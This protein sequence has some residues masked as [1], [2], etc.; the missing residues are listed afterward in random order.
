MHPMVGERA[1]GALRGAVLLGASFMAVSAALAQAGPGSSSTTATPSAPGDVPP[2]TGDGAAAV[3]GGGASAEIVVTGSRLRTGFTAPT[4][5]SVVGAARLEERAAPSIA[6]AL[7]EVPSFRPSNGPATGELA[8]TAGYVGGRV[9]DLRGLGAPRTLTLV[10]GK[11]FVPATTQATVDTN[12]IPSILLDRAE[13]VTGGASA[14]YGS[15]AVAGV[16][17]LILDKKLVGLK[18]SVQDVVTKYGDGNDP[19]VGIAYGAKISERLHLVIGGEYENQQGVGDC[20][21]RAFCR[22]E[23]L[24]FGRNP[25]Y[26]AIPALNILGDVRPWSASFNGVTTPPGSAYAGKL[27]PTLRPIDGITFADDG[28]PRRFQFGSPVNTLYQVGGE[29]KGQNIYFKDLFFVSPTERYAVTG[30]L[31]WDVTPDIKASVMVNYGHLRAE[32]SSPYYR[33]TALT[34]R[35]DNPFLPRSSDPTLDIPTLLRQANLTSFTLGKGFNEIG[36]TAYVTHD[37]VYRVVASLE[38]KLGG[39][40]SWDAYYQYGENHFRDDVTNAVVSSRIAKALDPVRN[41]AGQI[42]CR[43]NADAITTNDDP[44]C[45]AY[46][47]F[48]NQ[49]S[50]AAKAY[51][52]GNAFQT[53]VDT[54]HVAAANLRGSLFNLPYG[55]V[56]IAVG[57]EYRND[58]IAGDADALS[59]SLAF[60]AGNGSRISGQIAVAEGYVEGEVPLLSRLSFA[61]ELSLNGAV[62]RT[63]YRRSSDFFPSS[64]VNVT[65]YKF[66]GVYEPIPAIRFRATKS[67]DIRAP[68]V[69]ELFGPTTSLFGILNDPAKG[70]QQVNIPIFG[71]SNPN[72]APE[73]AD[74]ITAGIVIKPQGGFLGRFRASADYYNIKVKNA[75]AT[76]GQQNIATRCFQGDTLSCAQITRDADGNIIQIRDVFQNVNEQINRGIDGEINY[77]QPLGSLGNANLRLLATYVIDFITVDAVGPTDRAGQT[78]L[79]GGTPVGLPDLQLDA[80]VSW[81]VGRFTL[82]THVKYINKGFYNAAFIGPDDP[83]YNILSVSSAN[84]NSVPSRTYLDMLASYRIGA[85]TGRQMT[86]YFGVDNITNAMPPLNAGSHG[87]G[88]TVL[89]SPLGTTFKAGARVSF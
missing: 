13:V 20:Q 50:A 24:N 19:V 6:D 83:N 37:D 39:S 43:V 33:S 38:G 56:S 42:V 34:I 7:N 63:H 16:V 9:L 64:T 77:R 41:A 17:N 10:D 8:P 87:T 71:G 36:R 75:I 5:V 57:G 40:W 89:F 46:N 4:P 68:N 44:A 45:V 29:G 62:R 14:Q 82:N 22:T 88:N 35:A 59:K 51:V 48:G 58:H 28:T 47:P 86:V 54:Q 74:T 53:N 26:T 23:V 70:G 18:A 12:M 2:D 31:D 84:K 61:N 73:R 76:L 79:R 66:G 65:T 85:D 1:R 81:N 49:A 69:S 67:R 55:A 80:L 25:G 30:N 60:Y 32:Y 11:R 15:D 52:V 3:G 27:V 21:T 78:G 72:L